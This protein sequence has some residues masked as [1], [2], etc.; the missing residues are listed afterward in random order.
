MG[1][2]P[3]ISGAACSIENMMGDSLRGLV[4]S[5]VFIAHG[6]AFLAKEFYIV[7]ITNLSSI[8][9]I[10]VFAS[11]GFNICCAHSAHIACHKIAPLHRSELAA[12]ATHS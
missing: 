4:V 9:S 6:H 3:R 2:T 1:L 7:T 5:E 8:G 10:I 12:E 11:S